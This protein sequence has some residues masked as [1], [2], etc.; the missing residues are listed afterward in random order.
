VALTSPGLQITED[1]TA[2]RAALTDAAVAEFFAVRPLE[3]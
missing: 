2:R 3:F 1:F